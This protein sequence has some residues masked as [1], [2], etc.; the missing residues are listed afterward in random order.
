[1]QL[2]GSVSL[3]TG[4]SGAIGS[5]IFASLSQRGSH[6][7]GQYHTGE[8]EALQLCQRAVGLG[9]RAAVRKADL[10]R[11]D[12]ALDLTR[13]VLDAEGRIDI[14]VN[15]A[16]VFGRS[17][18]VEAL[19][20]EEWARTLQINLTAPFLLCRAV[21]PSMK[22]RRR[23]AIVNISSIAGLRGSGPV[24]YCAT[25]AGLL[26]LT[27]ALAR[28]LAPFNVTV[29]AVAPGPT[30]SQML[31]EQF[32]RDEKPYT[33]FGRLAKP[34]EVADVVLFLIEQT[35]ITGETINVSGGRHISL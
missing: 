12:Q 11:S 5:A 27:M 15:V 6:V 8:A 13:W 10:E 3:V 30:D 33:L 4:V 23:G 28:E 25:K 14:L 22:E 9:V 29:N 26:G 32:R 1:M 7:Y 24:P 34:A 16:A 17:E 21:A 31:S 20:P 35:F 19:A 18:A 2:Q